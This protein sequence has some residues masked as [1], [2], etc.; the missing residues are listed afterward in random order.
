MDSKS[1]RPLCGP[2]GVLV[3]PILFTSSRSTRLFLRW[4][5]RVTLN[6][7]RSMRRLSP[8]D[9]VGVSSLPFRVRMLSQKLF[10]IAPL[11]FRISNL[12]TLRSNVSF[13]DPRD[14]EIHTI[15]TGREIVPFRNDTVL[16][17]YMTLFGLFQLNVAALNRF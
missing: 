7:L 3:I 10:G 1:T 2:F 14:F 13:S 5:M 12:P 9:S 17:R 15:A 8:K 16:G 6:R 11:P 4:K